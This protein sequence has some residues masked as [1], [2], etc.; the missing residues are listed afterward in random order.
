VLGKA[1]KVRGSNKSHT[2]RKGKFLNSICRQDDYDYKSL[3]NC[4]KKRLELP[5]EC[6]HVIHNKVNEQK[7]VAFLYAIN[8]QLV[9]ATLKV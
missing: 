6:I 8:K 4:T 5:N 9:N 2:G 3:K 1:I 7:S